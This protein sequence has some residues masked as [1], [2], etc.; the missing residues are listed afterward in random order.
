MCA[1]ENCR[2]CGEPYFA[3]AAISV[4]EILPQIPRREFY[5]RVVNIYN[6]F[7]KQNYSFQGLG[8]DSKNYE[9]GLLMKSRMGYVAR[10]LV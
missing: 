2:W 7:F 9:L 3:G 5:N 6:E 1:S 8:N 10:I 4:S